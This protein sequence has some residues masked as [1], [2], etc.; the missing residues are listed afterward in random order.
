VAPSVAKLPFLASRQDA[1]VDVLN[2]PIDGFHALGGEKLILAGEMIVERSFGYASLP[3]D[4]V[5]DNFPHAA[6]S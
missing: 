6:G 2:R 1:Q 5:D 3:G 4:K